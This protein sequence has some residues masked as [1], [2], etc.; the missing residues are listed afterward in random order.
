MLRVLSAE[1][2]STSLACLCPAGGAVAPVTGP[3]EIRNV[4][5]ASDH[6]TWALIKHWSHNPQ[7][8]KFTKMSSSDSV[9]HCDVKLNIWV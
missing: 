3:S 5:E 4:R 1:L 8:V 9:S 7:S 6:Q 2:G